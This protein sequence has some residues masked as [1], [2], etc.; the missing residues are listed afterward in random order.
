ML[1]E[2]AAPPASVLST[3]SRLDITSLV[4][5]SPIAMIVWDRNFLVS[6]WNGSAEKVFG[7]TRDE[8]IGRHAADLIVPADIRAAINGV[9]EQLLE[10][11]GGGRSTNQNI[12][13][14]KQHIVCDWYNTLLFDQENQ[15]I[16][17]LSLVQDVT[18]SQ[19]Y[20]A[21]LGRAADDLE[22]LASALG[23][24]EQKSLLLG[25]A[26]LR[27]SEQR[28]LLL[29]EL[30]AAQEKLDA[31]VQLYRSL[32][33]T[34]QRFY[35]TRD[36]PMVLGMAVHFV[37]YA[38]QFERC[39]IL[40]KQAE[41]DHYRV[42]SF[43]GYFTDEQAQRIETTK[44]A[45][46]Q[47]DRF[48]AQVPVLCSADGESHSSVQEISQRLQMSEWALL[49]L[50]NR[51]SF[52][53]YALVA[54][55][56]GQGREQ[57]ATVVPNSATLVGLANLVSQVEA[58]LDNAYSYMQIQ[59]ERQSLEDKVRA[60]TR[61]L[62]DAKDAAEEANR[63]KSSFLAMMSHEIRT[64][65]N[66]VIGMTAL[67]LNTT[68]ND[69]Q[70]DFVLT[71]RN[72]GDALLSIIND[73]LDFSKIESGK[74]EL[75]AYDFSLR[76][77]I[78]GAIELCA[79]RS[80]EKSLDLSYEIAAGTPAGLVGDSTRLR[81]VLVNLIGNAVKF[82]ERGE[83]TIHVE[84]RTPSTSGSDRGDASS[85][86]VLIHFSVR[87]TGIGISKD[88]QERLFLPF[89]QGD[90]STTRKYGGTGL[91]LVISKRLT[92]LMGG[93]MWVEST[94]IPGEGATFHFEICAGLSTTI[95]AELAPENTAPLR[96]KRV[97]VLEDSIG[98]R[99]FV[100]QQLRDWGMTPVTI[101]LNH[102]GL[103]RLPAEGPIDAVLL[104]SA[105]SDGQAIDVTKQLRGVAQLSTVPLILMTPLGEQSTETDQ[106][107]AVLTKPLKASRLYDTLV[108]LLSGDSH[109]D[110]GA[111]REN[112]YA[113]AHLAEELPLRILLVED[114]S[115]NQRL[116]RLILNRM[117]YQADL[118]GNG[119]EALAA[120]RRQAYDVVLMDVQMPEMDGLEAT[121]RIRAEFQPQQQ[122]AIFAMTANTL[123]G[124]RERCL[125]AGM[126]DYLSKPIRVS[127]LI[128]SFKRFAAMP[129]GRAASTETAE[130]SKRSTPPASVQTP[131][132]PVSQSLK[133]TTY[134][135]LQK[136]TGGKAPIMQELLSL[137]ID[138]LS[139]LTDEA[140]RHLASGDLSTVHRAVHTLKSSAGEF[141]AVALAETCR[142]LEQLAAAENRE[143]LSKRMPFFQAEQA[144]V[145]QVMQKLLE[146]L[147]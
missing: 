132:V 86:S 113:I 20:E 46:H 11:R 119:I 143:E 107:A 76:E 137:F 131:P 15:V 43:E 58:A 38:L 111:E 108:D 145:L 127:E 14:L 69:E 105:A 115:T 2:K 117:G 6:D 133:V 144:Q 126:D 139:G 59:Q 13:K 93:R 103:S 8:A 102:D 96:E 89:S 120:L 85:P 30:Y 87:D 60:R 36:I 48:S 28:S 77:C 79:V 88:R 92:E 9:F 134:E 64:P 72:S 124:D 47:I 94:G 3:S 101:D 81:Q 128:A 50:R 129:R 83:V 21:A 98:A 35:E 99:Q 40:E 112:P 42:H 5:E 10:R 125:K 31:Q 51:N 54:G 109:S 56:W 104:S 55:N 66:G 29:G 53:S 78:E 16:G 135:R 122:P 44:I 26:A 97:L 12:T 62:R 75:E 7:F 57:A 100:C 138:D 32:H 110:P 84:R 4:R 41:E 114:N 80:A 116:A 141:G 123:Q 17:V 136:I 19:R 61:Q 39:V 147:S 74:L 1:D 118:A 71:I 65:M 130:P 23:E 45:V 121:R 90:A 146:T 140:V 52:A 18:A 33:Q 22:R 67:L 142:E 82:T 63:A 24:S 70:R 25:A 73:I 27:E 106:F 34:G 91:G 95:P 49:R 68:L 37:V